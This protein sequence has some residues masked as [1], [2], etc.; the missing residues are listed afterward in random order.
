MLRWHARR[1]LLH[2]K[3]GNMKELAVRVLHALAVSV[4][5]AAPALA[6]PVAQGPGYC[7]PMW[8]NWGWMG[9]GSLWMIVFIGVLIALIVFA[10]R[11][12]GSSG[13]PASALD[14][15]KER[16]ARG[17][18]DQAEFERRKKDIA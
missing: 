4:P 1:R 2:V 18:I 3:R 15:L 8:G 14:V 7:P 16:Y 6:Q 17:E 9:F 11:S 5:M 10:T 12:F 13:S